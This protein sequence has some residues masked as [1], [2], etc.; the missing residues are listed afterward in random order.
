MK[1]RRECVR[2]REEKC[3][4]F[5]L[6]TARLLAHEFHRGDSD[7]GAEGGVCVIENESA[8][9]VLSSACPVLS[10]VSS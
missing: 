1:E 6:L 5:S 10:S 4:S 9:P 3:L 7:E 8:C 2:D